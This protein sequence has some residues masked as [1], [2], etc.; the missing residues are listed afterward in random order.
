MAALTEVICHEIPMENLKI[1][2]FKSSKKRS[3]KAQEKALGEGVTIA[4]TPD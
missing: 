1:P 2:K 4:E 3:A